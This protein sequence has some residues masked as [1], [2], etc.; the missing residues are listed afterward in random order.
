MRIDRYYTKAGQSPYA[1]IE[2]RKAKSEIRNPDGSIVF[3]Q[4][5]IDVPAAWSHVAA[6]VLAQKYFRK[7]GVPARLKK[8]EE[9]DVPAFLWRSVADEAALAALPKA[10]RTTG[11]NAPPPMSSTGSPAPGPIG[12]GRAAISTARPTRR[13]SSTNCAT[14]SP[15]R[16]PRPIRR[17][18]ST[19]A[20]TGPMGSMVRARAIITSTTRREALPTRNPPTS[21]PSRMPV[22]SRPSRT[23]SSMTAASWICGCARRACSNTARAPART[24]RSCAARTRRFRAAANRRA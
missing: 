12:A 15:A 20:C 19:P 11:R 4:D 21:I 7:A 13:P 3:S 22:S 14:C 2:F 24:S 1:D 16:S 6:D 17:N 23:I 5:A 10:E 8:V 9:E 18:G